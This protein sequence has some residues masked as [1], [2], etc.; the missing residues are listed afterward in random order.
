MKSFIMFLDVDLDRVKESG[1]N[2]YIIHEIHTS[3][4]TGLPVENPSTP[5][6]LRW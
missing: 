3:L 2:I 5:E 4:K 1:R 6:S